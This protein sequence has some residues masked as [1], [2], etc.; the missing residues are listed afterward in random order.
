MKSIFPLLIVYT[1]FKATDLKELVLSS[2]MCIEMG[3]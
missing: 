2:E 3:A 1:F